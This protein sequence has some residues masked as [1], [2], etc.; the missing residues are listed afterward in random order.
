MSGEN[1]TTVMFPIFERPSDDFMPE[2]IECQQPEDDY[3]SN[4]RRERF[5][6]NRKKTKGLDVKHR[7]KIAQASKR[8]NR[9]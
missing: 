7:R 8:K 9:K 4:Y 6:N 3:D 5:G 1:R 2:I